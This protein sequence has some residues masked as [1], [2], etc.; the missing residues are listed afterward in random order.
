MSWC[1]AVLRVLYCRG[2]SS[3]LEDYKL[4]YCHSGPTDCNDLLSAVQTLRPTVLIGCDQMGG[5]PPFAFDQHV[6]GTM[7]DNAH[8]PLI[9]PL[10]ATLPECQL[11]DAYVW[12]G[13]RALVATC[14]A[15]HMGPM[16]LTRG[17]DEGDGKE[18]L[19]SQITSTY[20]FPGVGEQQQSAVA[21]RG[22]GIG[23]TM[24]IQPTGWQC[25]CSVA[26]CNSNSR[27]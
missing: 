25:H 1:I 13:G 9:F 3:T 16:S 10:T 27:L 17:V 24:A 14:A 8:H 26:H 18:L 4:P 20:I 21:V 5:P 11:R 2:D 23:R 22:Q 7:A 15:A 12:S 6:I 19:P